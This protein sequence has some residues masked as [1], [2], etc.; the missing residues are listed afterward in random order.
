MRGQP[1]GEGLAAG[2]EEGA[3]SPDSANGASAGLSAASSGSRPPAPR[4]LAHVEGPEP[5]GG[6]DFAERGFGH[7]RKWRP[8]PVGLVLIPPG[9]GLDAEGRFDL[10]LHF[11][12]AEP[13]RKE[14]APENLPL[15]IAAFDVGIISKDYE[16]VFGNDLILDVLLRAIEREVAKIA[17]ASSAGAAP[18]KPAPGKP[19]R[20]GR[21]AVSSWSAGFGA[22][23]HLLARPH[24]PF[25]A[26]VLLDSL[27]A[28]YAP[29]PS[30]GSEL[31]PGQLPRFVAAARDAAEGG[32]PFFLSF[33]EVGTD[34]YASTSEVGAFVVREV[35]ADASAVDVPA[36]EAKPGT[37][38]LLSSHE[39]GNFYVRG[40]A[41]DRKPDH[42]A[43]LRL[44]RPV[45]RD[46]VLPA[47]ARA[48]SR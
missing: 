2:R 15:V 18:G 13:V 41:G 34:G 32:P 44:I 37:L 30:P 11:H 40:Y 24:P 27:Y 9:G 36:S 4:R 45:V 26:L 42:C 16:R 29:R 6:C 39:R 25:D 12:G 23:R 43:Q 21:I 7:Y 31:L 28:P 10:L 8:L 14:L 46:L 38:R 33:T 48:K 1:A 17:A 35:V 20:V 47:F 3:G 19:A 22:V 5:G